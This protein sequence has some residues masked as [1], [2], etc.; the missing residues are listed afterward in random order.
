M[1]VDVVCR[2]IR[3]GSALWHT[4]LNQNL[5]LF[6]RDKH[7]QPLQ[8]KIEPALRCCL[9]PLSNR[10]WLL[11][12]ITMQHSP[13]ECLFSPPLACELTTPFCFLNSKKRNELSMH[14][15]NIFFRAAVRIFSYSRGQLTLLRVVFTSFFNPFH[16]PASNPKIPS[17]KELKKTWNVHITHICFCHISFRS[18]PIGVWFLL[19]RLTD[20]PRPYFCSHIEMMKTN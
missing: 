11:E 3:V 16:T 12:F 5:L 4:S 9:E 15:N 7:S 1:L 6:P 19:S 18:W 13:L 8:H 14:P 10:H 17:R 20:A 2:K